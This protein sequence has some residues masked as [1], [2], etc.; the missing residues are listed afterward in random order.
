MTHSRRRH[1]PEWAETGLGTREYMGGLDRWEDELL[2]RR[3][4]EEASE[5]VTR[6]AIERIRPQRRRPTRQPGRW[7]VVTQEQGIRFTAG[8][9]DDLRLPERPR[10]Q[11]RCYVEI[12]NVDRVL[13]ITLAESG[14]FRVPSA[15]T[16]AIGGAG[17]S[18]ELEAR[19]MVVG[20][21]YPATVE[22]D[23]IVVPFG[24][25]RTPSVIVPW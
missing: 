11:L 3:I 22:G 18:R 4:R 2:E 7:V 8:I 24:R 14:D 20:Q 19:G 1:A 25:V 5:V 23:A 16:G 21:R 13:R 12:H 17:L 15:R 10:E 9:G 6:P